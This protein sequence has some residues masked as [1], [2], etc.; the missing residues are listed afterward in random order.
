MCENSILIPRGKHI[1]ILA[2]HRSLN[3]LSRC[4]VVACRNVKMSHA[5]LCCTVNSLSLLTF[6][7][8]DA[9]FYLTIKSFQIQLKVLDHEL[10]ILIIYKYYKGTVSL[11][12]SAYDFFI[13]R[14]RKS[15]WEG[16]KFFPFIHTYIHTYI[17]YICKVCILGWCTGAASLIVQY[18]KMNSP[19]QQ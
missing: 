5:Q 11:V 17:Q 15:T 3:T 6:P 1:H 10:Q 12:F 9:D 13:K 14:T 7:V 4:R 18:T 8:V 19:K 16:D 2:F